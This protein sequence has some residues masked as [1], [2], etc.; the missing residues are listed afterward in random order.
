[1]ISI[2]VQQPLPRAEWLQQESWQAIA[3]HHGR[4][5]SAI[6]ANDRPLVVGSAKELV[7]CVA[8]VVLVSHGRVTGDKDEYDKVLGQAHAVVE[9]AAEYG[10]PSNDPLRQIP[11]AAKKMASQLREL[12]NR[13]GTG[14]GRPVVHEITDEVVEA[15]VHAALVWVR[16]ALARLQA[17]LLGAIEPLVHDLREGIFSKGDLAAR[18]AAANIPG[19][20]EP[21]QRRLGVA[22]GQ[23]SARETFNVRIEGVR[24]CADDLEHWPDAYRQGVVEG[25]FLNE[26]GQ[27]EARPSISPDCAAEVLQHHS[28]PDRVLVELRDVLGSAS[29]SVLFQQEHPAVF[30]AMREEIRRLPALGQRPWADIINDL[31]AYAPFGPR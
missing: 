14:H 2:L 30:T 21:E 25:L 5:G 28:V 22:V 9:H 3:D 7:E 13:F 27:V 19:L 26:D 1:M 15:S 8:R 6:A 17:V 29:W 16:W 31:E 20:D 24:A 4:L 11:N 10:L 23:R 18:L 12:R